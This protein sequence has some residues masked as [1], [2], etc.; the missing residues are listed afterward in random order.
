VTNESGPGRGAESWRSR[1]RRSEEPRSWRSQRSQPRETSRVLPWIKRLLALV[2]VGVTATAIYLLWSWWVNPPWPTT[3]LVLGQDYDRSPVA[4]VGLTGPYAD[5][6]T[7]FDR[8]N[9]S[10][11]KQ[12]VARITQPEQIGDAPANGTLILYLAATAITRLDADGK[13]E[14]IVVGDDYADPDSIGSSLDGQKSF[15]LRDVWKVLAKPRFETLPK[16]VF[17][18]LSRL[19]TDWRM[20]ILRSRLLD[21]ETLQSQIHDLKNLTVVCSADRGEKSWGSPL[22]GK[23]AFEHFGLSAMKAKSR[24]KKHPMLWVERDLKAH[25][26]Y[27]HVSELLARVANST[28]K[29]VASNRGTAQPQTPIY[30]S[31]EHVEV[32]IDSSELP[33]TDVAD[34]TWKEQFAATWNGPQSS[35]SLLNLWQTR[36]DIRKTPKKLAVVLRIMPLVWR[37]FHYELMRAESLAYAGN[38]TRARETLRK[39]MRTQ[40]ILKEALK[41]GSGATAAPLA[42]VI[43]ERSTKSLI[44]PLFGSR[45]APPEAVLRTAGRFI[46]SRALR[47]ASGNARQLQAAVATRTAAEK[48]TCGPLGTSAFVGELVLAA[49]SKR[50]VAEDFFFADGQNDSKLDQ[51][52]ADAEELY[53]AAAEQADNLAAAREILERLLSDLPELA[54]WAANGAGDATKRSRFV[55][56]HR[57]QPNWSDP[58]ASRSIETALAETNVDR[59]TPRMRI[60]RDLLRLFSSTR[61]LLRQWDDIANGRTLAKANESAQKSALVLRTECDAASKTLREIEEQI[62]QDARRVEQEQGDIKTSHR[63]EAADLV[64]DSLLAGDDRLALWQRLVHCDQELFLKPDGAPESRELGDADWQALWILEVFSFAPG[65]I[66]VTSDNAAATPSGG[67]HD[68]DLAALTSRWRDGRTETDRAKKETRALELERQIRLRWQAM[69]ERVRECADP[70]QKTAELEDRRKLLAEADRIARVVHGYDA[71]ELTAVFHSATIEHNYSPSNQLAQVE[72]ADLFLLN[73]RRH[74]RSLWLLPAAEGTAIETPWFASAANAF[75]DA[76]KEYL[77]GAGVNDAQAKTLRAQADA[78]QKMSVQLSLDAASRPIRL[79][80][81]NTSHSAD[82]R[83]NLRMNGNAGSDLLAGAVAALQLRLPDSSAGS[84]KFESRPPEPPIFQ[85]SAGGGQGTFVANRSYVFS[86]GDVPSGKSP[87]C[88]TQ[89]FVPTAFFRGRFRQGEAIQVDPCRPEPRLVNYTP[90]EDR[91][92]SL[93]VVGV[94]RRNVIFILDCSGSMVEKMSDNRSRFEHAK[95]ALRNA[96]QLLDAQNPKPQVGLI[97][98]G[99]RT[100]REGGKDVAN[101]NWKDN[102][103]SSAFTDFQNLIPIGPLNANKGDF[104]QLFGWLSDLSGDDPKLKAK[105]EPWGQ[106][107]LV[108][109]VEKA[110]E[111]SMQNSI[112]GIVVITDGGPN[113]SDD[114]DERFKKV[115]ER[116]SAVRVALRIVEIF[117]EQVFLKDL[118]QGQK[119]AALA[120]GTKSEQAWT[121]WVNDAKDDYKAWTL[122]EKICRDH[123]NEPVRAATPQAL[124]QG[125]LGSLVS[126]RDVAIV[127][128]NPS[129]KEEHRRLEDFNRSDLVL[130]PGEYAVSFGEFRDRAFPL[131]IRAGDRVTLELDWNKQPGSLLRQVKTR[132]R[133]SAPATRSGVKDDP[134][135]VGIESYKFDGVSHEARFV[136]RFGR[137]PDD[138]IVRRPRQV[139]FRIRPEGDDPGARYRPKRLDWGPVGGELPGWQITIPNWPGGVPTRV[140]AS[141]TMSDP[142]P[143]AR[144][145]WSELQRQ[146]VAISISGSSNHVRVKAEKTPKEEVAVTVLLESA[147]GSPLSADQLAELERM[148]IQIG[149]AEGSDFVPLDVR[150]SREILDE[151]GTLAVKF[152]V[153]PQLPLD[154]LEVGLTFG[155]SWN[156]DAIKLSQPLIAAQTDEITK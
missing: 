102:Q 152:Q 35:A 117:D 81:T 30:A 128:K 86:P 130:D 144:W 36:D 24:D 100:K 87:E 17:L 62:E 93:K 50:Y 146:G 156:R 20:G 53:R 143:D 68:L 111:E 114:W 48:T 126:R 80:S 28:T 122:F 8:L 105:L 11:H 96:L 33:P 42:I 32:S 137:D 65:R 41:S 45:L 84:P 91:S 136:I 140:D 39:A 12:T 107:P 94:D 71:A 147:P 9:D 1:D 131:S 57:E 25:V 134:A 104:L 154:K 149:R 44:E 151:D 19:T 73:A 142:V 37:E 78:M 82:T 69:R 22:L 49:D 29:W 13:P 72:L 27:L 3:I 6:L 18:D 34:G 110:W 74:L 120:K 77:D 99:H 10:A 109:A 123:H 75:L 43:G 125:V 26:N 89:S 103:P 153:D 23:S 7:S 38:F 15:P 54:Y 40:E 119:Q 5:E 145:M 67:P 98:Y 121:Q 108:G 106:T 138:R 79:W 118:A 92:A 116:L 90:I 64:S 124:K 21:K 66:A 113:D 112:D 46:E 59:L 51:A 135:W 83:F 115:L 14:I 148:R 139:D 97:A 4:Y 55:E 16:L 127:D 58:A 88:K 85:A 47:P 141:W 129:R 150:Y 132:F 56:L 76:A 63:Q 95:E 101:E 52:R 60:E 70:K 61:G 155:S 133:Y 2:G 31:T